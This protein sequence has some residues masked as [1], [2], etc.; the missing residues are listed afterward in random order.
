MYRVYGTRLGLQVNR[1]P[2]YVSRN[3][4][5]LEWESGNW[6]DNTLVLSSPKAERGHYD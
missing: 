4:I 1:R 6:L 3:G 2:G 5:A